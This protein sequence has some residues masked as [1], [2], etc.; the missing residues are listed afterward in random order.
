MD[1]HNAALAA[2]SATV[3]NYY[4]RKEQFRIAHGSTSSTRFIKGGNTVNIS[5]LSRILQVNVK[6]RTCIVEPNVPMDRLVEKTLEF[7]LIPPVVMEFPGIT[8]GGGYAG[9]S[10][11]SSSFKHG[12][13]NN[14]VNWVEM[15]LASGQV[16]RCSKNE[17]A[18]LFHGAAGALGSLG[19]TTLLELQLLEAKEYV[20]TT[21]H[22]VTSI[23][24]AI[25]LVRE[26]TERAEIDYI[27]GIL[28]SQ[29]QGVVVTGKMADDIDLEVSVQKFSGPW[30]PW[31]YQH[32]QKMISEDGALPIVEAVPLTEYL[33]RYDRGGFWVGTCAFDY[34]MTP[35]S[36]YT[37]WFL[38]DFL[39]PRMMYVALH[40]SG[41]AKK[42]IIQDLAF[43]FSTSEEFIRY[44]AETF[45]IWPLWLCPLR[46]S[47][48]PT[49]HP[50]LKKSTGDAK[51]PELM[52]NIGL[53][54]QAPHRANF[55]QVNRNLEAALQD[56]GGMKWLYAQT[57]YTQPEFWAIYKREWYD[58]LR[59]KYD[60]MSLPSVYEKVK[61]DVDAEDTSDWT[62]SIISL[63][64]FGG[65]YGIWR[66]IKSGTYL[67]ARSASWRS[68]AKQNH[69]SEST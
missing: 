8:V 56:L 49:F 68:T 64:P 62:Q 5:G 40:A 51:D 13:F 38:D 17:H 45:D 35:F 66:A 22:R 6:R 11:E 24:G 36:D 46:Q 19:I 26:F 16:I 27:D 2:I 65:L 3:R 25:D 48:F 4:I 34:F 43:P 28:F 29:H 23:R 41:Q 63:W 47:P 31:F 61:Y 12:F 9:T 37:R 15:V 42:M 58:A 53:W 54:G 57:F 67:Q 10:G 69:P 32:A 60:A 7:G 20:K 39:H 33:F 44:T 30:D 55:V 14:S 21:Y 59:E 52:L 18:D 50:S 1:E